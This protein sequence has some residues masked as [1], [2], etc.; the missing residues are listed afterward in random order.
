[1][2]NNCLATGALYMTLELAERCE[3]EPILNDGNATNQLMVHF[4]F[5]KSGYRVTVERIP[6]E[7]PPH[8]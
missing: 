6:N 8:Q 1:M 2:A 5:L 4:D 3:V 7:T